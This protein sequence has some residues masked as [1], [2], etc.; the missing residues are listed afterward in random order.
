MALSQLGKGGRVAG[1][2]STDQL[3][4]SFAFHVLDVARAGAKVTSRWG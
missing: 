2:R 4:L 1:Q 3:D